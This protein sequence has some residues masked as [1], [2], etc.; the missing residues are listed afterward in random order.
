MKSHADAPQA[1]GNPKKGSSFILLQGFDGD[2]YEPYQK[3]HSNFTVET[4]DRN[5]VDL[6][7][8]WVLNNPIDMCMYPEPQ[9][10]S[11]IFLMFL[12]VDVVFVILY[13]SGL[14]RQDDPSLISF[15][16]PFLQAFC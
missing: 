10:V 14:G 8:S 16:L 11:A 13:E 12:Y 6:L 15:R 3:S 7:R 5:I 1:I 4:H 2:G 9:T